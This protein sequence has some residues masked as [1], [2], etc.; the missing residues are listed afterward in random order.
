[1]NNLYKSLIQSIF[2]CN[3]FDVEGCSEHGSS[4][5]SSQ[6]FSNPLYYWK[7]WVRDKHL[8]RTPVYSK[9]WVSGADLTS[10]IRKHFNGKA[11]RDDP[12]RRGITA[13]LSFW[14]LARWNDWRGDV[15]R[16]H[17]L[18]LN[19]TWLQTAQTAQEVEWHRSHSQPERTR[20]L[21]HWE[22]AECTVV[23]CWLNCDTDGIHDS[24][25]T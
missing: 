23:L 4:P 24:W 22:H 6:P 9:E 10:F 11:Q 18:V 13:L 8:P 21:R 19:I 7:T 16:P 3:V 2:S 15:T 17:K 12:T 14:P 20:G 25:I 1:M 5:I